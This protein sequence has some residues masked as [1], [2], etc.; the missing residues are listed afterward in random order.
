MAVAV[1]GGTLF[2]GARVVAAS[3]EANGTARAWLMVLISG[4]LMTD[5]GGDGLAPP[6]PAAT[7]QNYVF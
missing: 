1:A 6:V 2:S 3:V 4:V 7:E 5:I